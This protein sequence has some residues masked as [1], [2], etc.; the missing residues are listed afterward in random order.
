MIFY[1][2]ISD[3]LKKFRHEKTLD[4]INNTI[5]LAILYSRHI[6]KA[7]KHIVERC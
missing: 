5:N 7:L 4:L 3:K 2:F 6:N 1:I